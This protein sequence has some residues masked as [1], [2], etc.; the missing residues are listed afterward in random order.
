MYAPLS[1]ALNYGLECLSEIHVEGLPEFKDHIVFVPSDKDATSD[2][3]LEGSLFE[4]EVVLM[5]FTTACDLLKI[6]VT[7]SLSVSWFVSKIPR[8]TPERHPQADPT[9]RIGWKD[10]LSPVEV[11]QYSSRKWP[12]L[13]IFVNGAAS[14]TK[15]DADE[16][17][18]TPRNL[19]PET[20]SCISE[21]RTRKIPT[22][23]Y[24]HVTENRT[25]VASKS[26]RSNKRSVTDAEISSETSIANKRQNRGP[27]RPHSDQTETYA[28]EKL[29]S[30]YSI[31]H[32]L[33]LLFQGKSPDA[34]VGFKE[35]TQPAR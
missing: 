23:V 10:I 35:F 29:S 27:S 26:G 15:K 16:E 9:Y 28:G 12:I 18:A 21:S 3:D 7:R 33:N 1:D 11:K 31:S 32:T 4:P 20:S 19:D 34:C 17:L 30:S 8:T 22:L 14:I 13:E 24:G 6:K 2:R 25:V 5:R